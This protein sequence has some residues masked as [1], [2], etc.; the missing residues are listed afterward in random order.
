MPEP[1]VWEL[2]QFVGEE[3]G[4]REHFLQW[5]SPEFAGLAEHVYEV[6]GKPEITF[7]NAWDIFRAMS[8]CFGLE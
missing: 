8:A 2:R 7:T 1:I 4:P 3:V 6:L 5:V